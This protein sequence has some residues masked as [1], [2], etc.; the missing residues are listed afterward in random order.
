M[1]SFA[2]NYQLKITVLKNGNVGIN[3]TS[4]LAEFHVKGDGDGNTVFI[5]NNGEADINFIDTQF[6][7]PLMC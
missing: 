5:E 6:I 7:L 3:I 4:P 1:L 2:D